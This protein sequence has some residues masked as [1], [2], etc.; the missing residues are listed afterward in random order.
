MT[1]RAAKASEQLDFL[2]NR[3][4]TPKGAVMIT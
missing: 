2:N 4:E 3:D 1:G